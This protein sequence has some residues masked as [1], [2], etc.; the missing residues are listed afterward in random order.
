MGQPMHE[1]PQEQL[2]FPFFLFI[3][4]LAITAQK[5]SAITEIITIDV[6]S[7][8]AESPFIIYFDFF[9]APA[10]FLKTRYPKSATT[11]SAKTNP[12]IIGVLSTPYFTATAKLPI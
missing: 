7:P 2:L 6:R 8:I 12:T 4:S 3:M 9:A 1:P 5:A 10:V 11:R